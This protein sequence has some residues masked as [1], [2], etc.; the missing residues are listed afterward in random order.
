LGNPV[1][2]L[3]AQCRSWLQVGCHR[4]C[5]C[6]GSFRS[7]RALCVERGNGLNVVVGGMSGKR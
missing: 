7:E 4:V 3:H 5:D 2:A 6:V 1:V